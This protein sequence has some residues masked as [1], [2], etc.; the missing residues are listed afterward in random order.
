VADTCTKSPTSTRGFDTLSDEIVGAAFGGGGVGC[1]GEL[2]SQPRAA[3]VT[4]NGRYANRD[5]K[6]NW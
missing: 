1:I 4:M 2:P 6:L 3:N 5:F